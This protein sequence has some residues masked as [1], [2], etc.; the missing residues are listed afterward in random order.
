MPC[1]SLCKRCGVGLGSS[2]SGCTVSS[3]LV[4]LACLLTAFRPLISPSN[5][6]LPYSPSVPTALQSRA[7][8]PNHRILPQEPLPHVFCHPFPKFLLPWGC[9]TPRKLPWP[10]LCGAPGL[11]SGA[12]AM[13]RRCDLALRP[14]ASVPGCPPALSPGCVV[15]SWS[16]LPASAP[17]SL[18][19]VTPPLQTALGVRQQP[20]GR[21]VMCIAQEMLGPHPQFGGR[22]W[23]G[24]KLASSG[25]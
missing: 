2:G 4:I 18:L 7:S 5:S 1:W 24:L 23:R 19:P 3:R 20:A 14:P 12:E 11:G 10:Q 9:F 25:V 17:A 15:P 16:L 13:A 21:D 6:H 8:S 22:N